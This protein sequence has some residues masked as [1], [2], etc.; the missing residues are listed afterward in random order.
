MIRNFGDSHPEIHSS[1]FVAPNASVIGRVKL[2]A[3]TSIWYNAVLRA[4]INDIIIGEYSNIQDNVVI[5]VDGPEHKGKPTV[6]GNKVTVGHSAILHGCSVKDGSLI[7]MGAC[8]L[9]GAEIGEYTIVGAKAL[10]L[11]NKIIPPRS[12]VVGSPAKVVRSLTDEEIE[13][14]KEHALNYYH[15]GELYKLEI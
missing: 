1:C 3:Y 10:V 14:L 7:G 9:D 5:H 4:D 2:G 11:S 8:I 6:I 15:L 13:S 12:L